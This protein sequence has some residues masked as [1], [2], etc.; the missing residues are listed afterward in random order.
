M[1]RREGIRVYT[2]PIHVV[3]Q[4]K[5]TQHC[6]AII[7]KKRKKYT[8]N[9]I[10]ASV[11]NRDLVSHTPVTLGVNLMEALPAH[12]AF[13]TRSEEFIRRNWSEQVGRMRVRKGHGARREVDVATEGSPKPSEAPQLSV[14]SL[15]VTEGLPRWH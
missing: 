13:Q 9:K 2:W 7:L 6:K 11:E 1:L 15:S 5:L 10:L 4:Q 3:V 8:L 12:P 14:L